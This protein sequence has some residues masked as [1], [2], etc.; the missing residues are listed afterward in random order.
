MK[1]SLILTLQ[2]ALYI[3]V[4][5]ME[6][7]QYQGPDVFN[8]A[9]AFKSKKISPGRK[10][11][12]KQLANIITNNQDKA[13]HDVY[14]LLVAY[15]KAMKTGL[16]GRSQLRDNI[17]AVIKV[18]DKAYYLKKFLNI[19][20]AFPDRLEPDNELNDLLEER[21][22]FKKHILSLEQA[23]K[24]DEVSQ[25]S[26]MESLLFAEQ[27][28][29]NLTHEIQRLTGQNKAL[30]KQVEALKIDNEKF[31]QRHTGQASRSQPWF[32]LS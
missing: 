14:D 11:D 4:V 2:D 19:D 6:G 17:Y 24:E 18:Q 23:L 21:V 31:K 10:K 3:Y 27:K 16:F 9:Y 5:S 13:A 20:L 32:K 12:I 25:A 1:E 22:L 26:L 30:Q 7:V 15:L 8:L 29:E 28:I